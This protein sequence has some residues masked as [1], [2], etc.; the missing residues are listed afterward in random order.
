MHKEF[1]GIPDKRDDLC[2]RIAYRSSLLKSIR[3][4][5]F[6]AEIAEESVF[7]IHDKPSSLREDRPTIYMVWASPSREPEYKNTAQS[8]LP[9]S[10]STP[11]PSWLGFSSS[12]NRRKAVY[13]S[14]GALCGASTGTSVCIFFS[15]ISFDADPEGMSI[16]GISALW[17]FPWKKLATLSWKSGLDM[18]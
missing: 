13:L 1:S 8:P 5:V 15:G 7:A 2:M 9:W 18:A 10:N 16:A 17:A 6:T 12:E 11:C 3:S 4:L 14:I